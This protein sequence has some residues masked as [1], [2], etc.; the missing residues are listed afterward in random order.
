MPGNRS[1]PEHPGEASPLDHL[2]SGWVRLTWDFQPLGLEKDK[3]VLLL[4]TG[5]LAICSGS[6]RDLLPRGRENRQKL[7]GCGW[8]FREW[9][10]GLDTWMQE[11][12][13]HWL[14]G[15]CY[16]RGQQLDTASKQQR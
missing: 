14:P 8:M 4:A 13:R 2:D 16:R 15:S 11:G 10:V 9:G 12:R 7:K 3:R 6:C 1:S 5:F